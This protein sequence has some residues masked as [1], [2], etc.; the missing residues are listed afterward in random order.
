M[1]RTILA[2]ATA[3]LA[4][5]TLFASAAEACISCSYVPEV[6]HSSSTSHEPSHYAKERAYTADKERSARPA[7]R[8]VKS[9]PVAKKV[10][11]AKAAPTETQSE[12]ENST[13]ST[14]TLDTIGTN[15]KKDETAKTAPIKTQAENENSTIST[16]ALVDAE[17]TPIKEAKVDKNVGCKKFFPTVGMTLTVPCE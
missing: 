17:E 4:A 3:L 12:N 15:A 13:I 14:A 1:T 10:E 8:V 16:A 9:E 7:K 2:I 6:L 5:P 11:T